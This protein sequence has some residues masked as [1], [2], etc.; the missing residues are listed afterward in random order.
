VQ[1]DITNF[2]LM[3]HSLGGFLSAK[4]TLKYPTHVKA[5][6]LI[7]PV[8]LPSPPTGVDKESDPI[9][10]SKRLAI[11][12]AAWAANVTPQGILRVMGPR[13][14][15]FVKSIVNRRFRG[16]ENI[17]WTSE[18]VDIMTDYL[19]HISAADAS[20][21]YAMNSLLAPVYYIDKKPQKEDRKTEFSKKPSPNRSHQEVRVR[22]GVYA[23][24]PLLGDIAEAFGRR[25][26]M[27]KQ[28]P[29]L[30][31]FGDK[32]WLAYE[33]AHDD[34][35]KLVDRDGVNARLDIIKNSG[36]HLYLENP[37]DFFES[38][39]K[40]ENDQCQIK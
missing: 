10:L 24:E 40:W 22:G 16:S 6:A 36:H 21:E 25:S 13:G 26:T 34:V 7:S 17:N 1:K 28:I 5:L 38:L 11:I 33:E 23:R 3:G 31:M 15:S 19:Y 27:I 4:Y 12:Q 29:L 30:V 2:T 35:R 32:D 37:S 18:E 9:E 14:R 8:G 20:G 39:H